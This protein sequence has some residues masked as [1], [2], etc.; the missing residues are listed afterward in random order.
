M[1]NKKITLVL[2]ILIIFSGTV[3]YKYLENRQ[4]GQDLLASVKYN[5]TNECLLSYLED[6]NNLDIKKIN[7]GDKDALLHLINMRGYIDNAYATSLLAAKFTAGFKYFL[8]DPSDMGTYKGNI[9]DISSK[10]IK[11]KLDDKDENKIKL[12]T[13]DIEVIYNYYNENNNIN[14]NKYSKELRPKLKFTIE[15][16]NK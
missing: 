2:S 10:A 15:T 8:V 1:K 7:E 16:E 5:F 14:S 12:I 6:A 3:L 13:A 9:D 4:N 11:G